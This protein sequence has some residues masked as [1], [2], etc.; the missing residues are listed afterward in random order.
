MMSTRIRHVEVL[1]VIDGDTLVVNLNGRE[2]SLRLICVDTEESHAGSDKPVTRAGE[3]AKQFAIDYFRDSNG[4]PVCIDI[5]FDTQDA[6]DVCLKKHRG[7]HGR[8]LCYVHK[9]EENFNLKLIEMGWSPYFVKYGQ[10]RLYHR[11]MSIAEAHAQASQLGIW[12]EKTNAG[13]ERRNYERLIPWWVM[14]SQVI[15]TYR[16]KGIK[17]G[18][19]S[20]RL[21]YDKILNGLDSGQAVSVLCD[22]QAGVNQY[23][24]DG[25]LIYAGSRFHKF[26]LWIPD[27]HR[28]AGRSILHLVERRY[29][30][31]GRGYLYIRGTVTT[32]AGVPQIEL[33]ALEQL[34]DFTDFFDENV[35]RTFIRG[36]R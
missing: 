2:E 1:R 16:R 34:S 33:L 19:L 21:D 32:F 5:E 10:S 27:I 8:L 4:S 31:K 29:S 17:N 12:N 18:V 20:I 11:M 35:I 26:N 22:L 28:A 14:R 23:P 7:N 25:A 13:G 15:E 36:K 6:L 9:G 24:G 3:L 30:G